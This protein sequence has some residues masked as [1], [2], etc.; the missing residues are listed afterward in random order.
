MARE[1]QITQSLAA[2]ILIAL[3]TCSLSLSQTVPTTAL[4]EANAVL[5]ASKSEEAATAFQSLIHADGGD[6]NAWLGLGQ[7][8]EN[9]GQT[10][11]ALTA[12][13]RVIDL[14]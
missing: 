8:Q 1:F 10:E 7:A 4:K 5:A 14:S 9:L 12:Y 13:L 3:A 6:L 2:G 11:Q